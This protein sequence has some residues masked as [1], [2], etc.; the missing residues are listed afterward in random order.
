MAAEKTGEEEK[1]IRKIKRGIGGNGKALCLYKVFMGSITLRAK[2]LFVITNIYLQYKYKKEY[3]KKRKKK[4]TCDVDSQRSTS[5]LWKNLFSRS[6]S[7]Y[8]ISF[9]FIS[10]LTIYTVFE[11][12]ISLA[13]ITDALNINVI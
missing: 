7:V 5:T 11:L 4:E 6:F 1:R 13:D 9:Y 3:I 10:F 8:F 2:A 12:H